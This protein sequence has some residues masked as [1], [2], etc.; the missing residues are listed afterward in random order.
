MLKPNLTVLNDFMGI[1]PYIASQYHR[2]SERSMVSIKRNFIRAIK[3]VQKKYKVKLA[4]FSYIR[5]HDSI[6]HTTKVVERKWKRKYY[7]CIMLGE[8]L[9]LEEFNPYDFFDDS[10][11]VIVG[12]DSSTIVLSSYILREIFRFILFKDYDF[13]DNRCCVDKN[14]FRAGIREYLAHRKES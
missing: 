13:E 3:E 8:R 1:D 4:G 7:I 14:V 11:Y 2:A 12:V 6:S 10:V 5:E 9:Y